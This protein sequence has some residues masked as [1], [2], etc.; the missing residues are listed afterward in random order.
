MSLYR[1]WPDGTVQY[2]VDTPHVHMS[3]DYTEVWAEDEDAASLMGNPPV[4]VVMGAWVLAD[5]TFPP[6]ETPV[7]ALVAGEYCILERRTETPSWEDTYKAFDY[8]DDPTDDGQE[9][10]DEEVTHWMHLPAKPA[11]APTAE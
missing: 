3:D 10:A 2:A 1:V 8:W 5:E 11:I 4:V 7:L 9:I 6:K